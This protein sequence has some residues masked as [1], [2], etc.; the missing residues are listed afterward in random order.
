MEQQ[1]FFYRELN[2]VE[3]IKSLR[4][5]EIQS[6][7]KHLSKLL[8]DLNDRNKSKK[9]NNT[10][11]RSLICRGFELKNYALKNN[12]DISQL[13]KV[14]SE[15][16]EQVKKYMNHDIHIEHIKAVMSACFHKVEGKVK[17]HLRKR[18][19]SK[20]VIFSR[21]ICKECF[22]RVQRLNSDYKKFEEELKVK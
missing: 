13:E 15:F 22:E 9:L 16:V 12:K 5:F 11:P 6:R 19:D 20:A 2:D 7:I 14:I 8:C 1:S 18:E 17:R 3:N 21:C 10:F 4:F